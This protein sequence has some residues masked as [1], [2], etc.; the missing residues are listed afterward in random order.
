[1]TDK[2]LDKDNPDV[3]FK[4][5]NKSTKREQK[6]FVLSNEI[7]KPITDQKISRVTSIK[8]LKLEK[9]TPDN[10]L[11]A[12]V[13]NKFQERQNELSNVKKP[14]RR[15][16]GIYSRRRR[17]KKKDKEHSELKDQ[18][19]DSNKDKKGDEYGKIVDD[20]KDLGIIK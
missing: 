3:L 9:D 1:M 8:D 6:K 20:L 13:E 7:Y 12:K 11:L 5:K 14:K 10:D 18:F 4:Y 15:L 17:I 16:R 19:K 2:R